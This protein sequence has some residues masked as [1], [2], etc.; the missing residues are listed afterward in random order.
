MYLH[1][2]LRALRLSFDPFFFLLG[3]LHFLLFSFTLQLLNTT[4]GAKVKVVRETCVNLL[5]FKGSVLHFLR[6]G[7]S[8][9]VFDTIDHFSKVEG[10][11]RQQPRILYRI[12]ISLFS[13]SKPNECFNSCSSHF[14]ASFFDSLSFL[15]FLLF[16]STSF[17]CFKFSISSRIL[18]FSLLRTYFRVKE[19]F[20][21]SKH[22]TLRL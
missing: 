13:F 2:L 6:D 14:L 18:S 21:P 10:N 17:F 19:M 12:S 7:H 5:P 16:P 8:D 22:L 20:R 4:S 1:F 3:K 9:F 11:S 15:C